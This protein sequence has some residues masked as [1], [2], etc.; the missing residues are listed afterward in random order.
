MYI[1]L[2]GKLIQGHNWAKI[3]KPCP[4]KE[5]KKAEKYVGFAFPEELKDLLRET[6]GDHWFLLSAEEMVDQVRRNREILADYLEPDEFQ[7]KVN[8]FVY[9]ASN[10]CGDYYGYRVLAN[11]RTDDTAIYIWEHELFE[12]REVA[13]DIP[14][15]ITKYY[16]GEI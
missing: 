4:E 3:Q 5:I 6:N 2:I 10:G 16:N 11:G 13:K 14:E 8:R 15:L 7:E 1:E 12:I 9:F